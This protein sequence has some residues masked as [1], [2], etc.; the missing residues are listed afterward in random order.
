MMGG[1][2][3]DQQETPSKLSFA[4]DFHVGKGETS[5]QI[6]SSISGTIRGGREY[7]QLCGMMSLLCRRQTTVHIS[8]L[9]L[10]YNL[11]M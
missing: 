1:K 10:N 11:Q 4:I 7:T 5:K 3:N 2:A 8:Q 9:Q 6:L